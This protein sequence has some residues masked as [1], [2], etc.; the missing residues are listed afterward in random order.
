MI[1][2]M[3]LGIDVGTTSIKAALFDTAGTLLESYSA[4]Y[5][6]LHGD[7]GVVEQ[8][9]DIW[10]E[11]INRA[12][13]GFAKVRDLT[14]LRAIGITSQVNTH[15]FID[16]NG[17]PLTPAVVWQDGRCGAQAA[18]LDRQVSEQEKINW[19]GAPM[20]V[21]ASHCLA[22]MKW[23]ADHRAD[24]WDKTRYVL[25]PKDYCILKLTGEIVSDPISNIGL[26]DLDLNYIPT[27][28]DLVP[29]AADRLAPLAGMADIAGVVKPGH[30]CA[31][32]PVAV[33]TM[34]AWASMFGV[35]VQQPGQ[36][37]YLSGTSEVLGVV[38]KNV[39][40]TPGVLV[41]PKIGDLTLHAGPTQSGGA[42][43]L[44]YCKMFNTTPA[45][46]AALV[47]DLDFADPCPLFLPHLQGE[48]APIWDI[49]ARGTLL[50]IDARTGK[51]E[52]ARA[53][54]EGVGF[55]ARWLAE[56]LS[57][58][59]GEPITAFNCGGGGFQSDIW[60]QIRADIL[61]ALLLRS[62]IS[63][64]GVLGAA[65]LAAVAGGVFPDLNAALAELV[66]YDKS[67]E[68]ESHKSAQYSE[69]FELYK[70]TYQATRKISHM[71][72]KP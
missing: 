60:N 35:G 21:D 45:E 33:C 3:F 72:A 5:E 67:Y 1:K 15:V 9:P 27:L 24:V 41:F 54:Y 43:V 10:V 23:M 42:S 49:D 65:G 11:H 52:I 53:V 62:S 20:P 57:A 18:A 58:S 56:T 36:A 68:P 64:P 26:V 29:G 40:P 17:D 34:D 19:W 22:R 69:R 48:R 55:S 4:P 38:S 6:T 28:L 25:L 14:C 32:V 71:L 31:G 50:G 46:M 39:T 8:D 66:D 7:N 44:W 16:S 59:S 13:S 63:N 70:E 12:M 37:F 30:T 61:G 51:A 2:D 47:E